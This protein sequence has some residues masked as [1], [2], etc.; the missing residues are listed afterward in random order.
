ML[1]TIAKLT[2]ATTVATGAIAVSAPAMAK[3]GDPVTVSDGVTIDPIIDANLRY[4]HV[5]QDNALKNANAVTLRV[6]AGAELNASGFVLHAEAMGTLAIDDHYNDTIPGNGIEPYSVVP[7]PQNVALDQVYVGYKSKPITALIGRQR[8]I[9]DN[10]RFVGNVGWRQN[11][12]LFDALRA[13][14][15][16]GPVTYDATYANSQRTIFGNDSP[17]AKFDG[18]F[19]FLNGGV[20]LKVAK[21]KG[22]AYLIDYETRVAFSSQ[23]YGVLASGDVPLGGKAKLSYLASYAKQSDYGKN[24]VNYSAEYINGELGASVM[25]FGL[26]AGYEKLGS[27]HGFAAFQTPLATAHAFQGWA[28]LFLTTPAN[29]IQDYYG[30]LSKKLGDMGPLKGLSAAVIYHKFDSDYA[31]I[32]YGSE[33]DAS[34]GFTVSNYGVLFKYANYNADKFGVDTEKFWV[35]LSVKY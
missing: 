14:G 28:D 12:Q 9:L 23:T 22:F 5:D 15:Q 1:R 2:L 30:G 35:Q 26:K 3:A 8:I 25:G 4:E 6:R 11:E 34:L 27:D 21:V 17:N 31:D 29:G 24:P 16:F 18:D 32:K 7:D 19:F 33:W 20:D 13:Y 10:A